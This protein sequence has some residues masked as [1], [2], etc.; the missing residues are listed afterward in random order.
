MT[1]GDKG[2]PRTNFP[3]AGGTTPDGDQAVAASELTFPDVPRSRLEEAI[4]E[5]TAHAQ[6]VLDAQGRLRALVRANA[7]VVADLSLPVVLR[8][9][10]TAARELAHARYGAVGV[11]GRHGELEQFVHVGMDRRTVELIGAL[12]VGRGVLGELTRHPTP[13]RI[14]DLGKHPASTGFPPNHP[15]MRSFL[16]VPIRVHGELFGNLYMSD[17]K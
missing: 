11:L 13:L 16:G 7:D 8:K 3:G 1:N 12:P 15:P 10:V 9:I 4:G 6:L 5:L 14:D 2:E 17:R